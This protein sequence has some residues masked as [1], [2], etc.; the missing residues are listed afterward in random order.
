MGDLSGI[1]AFY[2]VG[3]NKLIYA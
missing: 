3:K 1:N 2:L